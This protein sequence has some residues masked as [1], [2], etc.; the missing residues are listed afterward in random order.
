MEILQYEIIDK[1]LDKQRPYYDKKKS[2]LIF[3]LQGNYHYCCQA[4]IYNPSTNDYSYFL[5]LAATKFNENCVSCYRDDYGRF[6]IRA[7][8]ELKTYITNIT[9]DDMNFELVLV[10]SNENY[11]A[12][13]IK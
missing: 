5:L 10:E 8:G 6:K 4:K 2:L 7:T 3:R 1:K 9:S 12:W 11:D 13:Q